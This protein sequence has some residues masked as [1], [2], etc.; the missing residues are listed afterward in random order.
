MN[1]VITNARLWTG[2]QAIERA[3]VQVCG[4][5]IAY[6]GP[7]DDAPAFDADKVIDARGGIVMP[8]LVNAH[9]HLPMTLVRGVGTDL[10]L[11]DWLHSIWPLEDM[12][13]PDMMRL[14]TQLSALEA[15]RTGTTCFADAYMQS[16]AIAE[17][18]DDAGMR[19]NICRMMTGDVGPGKLEEQRA[20]YA[21]WHGA[22]DGRI[23]VYMGL[24]AE[25]TT[26]ERFVRTVAQQAGELG[27]GMHVHV[28]ETRSEVEECRARRGGRSPVRY[29]ADAGAFDVPALAAHCVWVND[30]DMDIMAAKGVSP[31]HNPVSNL[32]LASGIAP[33]ERM[34]LKGL[35]VAL[36][37]D[38]AASNNTMDMFEELKLT[39]ILQKG[40]AN[41]ATA[42]PAT[43]ALAIASENGA[44]ALGFE[45]VG[46]IKPG[47]RADI[48]ML[49]S[50]TPAHTAS[51]DIPG[52]LVYA[53]C[54]AD[55]RMTMVDGRVLYM[56]G[57]YTTLDAERIRA[58]FAGAVE[59]LMGQ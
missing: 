2:A 12:L 45:G 24:H 36:G 6:A 31:V 46:L 3:C 8:G 27:T 5:V 33:V 19:L 28:S 18:V 48:V 30:D 51:R 1:T 26:E 57:A 39:A 13:T 54:G 10:P 23:R 21:R 7:Q 22:G 4:A 20:L 16:D 58:D 41:I 53:T 9:T 50:R 55:V 25:Y 47:Y 38:G 52:A 49:D 32:K 35:N 14:G 15:L 43:A 11:M 34:R 17:A 40:A 42:M 37:T 29:L 56:D 44:R 59:R